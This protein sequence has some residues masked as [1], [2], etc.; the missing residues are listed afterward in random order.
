MPKQRSTIALLLPPLT[1]SAATPLHRQLFDALRAA[2]LDGRLGPEARLPASRAL[3]R[4]LGISRTTVMT[5]YDQLTAEGFLIG[6]SG[7]GT[8]VSETMPGDLI[9]ARA[10]A[11][12]AEAPPTL[13]RRGAVLAGASPHP[14]PPAGRLLRPFRAGY[15]AV[16]AFPTEIWARLAARRWRRGAASLLGYGDP[17]GYLPLRVAIAD[18]LRRSRGVR[19]TEA[20]VIIVSGSQQGFDLT[21][22]LL[23]DPGDVAWVEN[24]GYA[25][26]SGAL[27]GAG[28]RTVPIP[29]DADGLDIA[30]GERLAPEARLAAVTPSHQYPAGVTMTLARR[31]ALLEW[32][33]RASAWVLED[34]Y[35]AEFRYSGRALEA[36]QGLD[37]EG[38]VIYL[39]T[40]S[41]VLAPALRLGYLVV[42][43]A[44]VDAF[45]T[46]VD[47]TSRH[48]P[49]IEQAV[50]ADFI[51]EGHFARH[52]RRMQALY[53]ERQGV[54]VEAAREMAG[55]MLDVRP[56]E[57]GL[58]VVGWLPPG[59]SAVEI[60]RRASDRGV[61]VY[62][63]AMPDEP[64]AG[65]M[66]GYAPFT[67]AA[68]RESMTSL[69]RVLEER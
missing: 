58:H 10:M 65:L 46:A 32:A 45:T 8:F 22:R 18:Y 66:L 56:A 20:Q 47:V 35:D 54:L 5:A 19:C 41:K 1:A 7:S 4:E 36:L 30:A 43:P 17:A 24:P 2:M 34:D 42:P 3:A 28:V 15:P 39:G 67:P 50:L 40:F 29:V 57:A 6:R 38:R 37:S 25:G 31:L 55:D 62:P 49:T 13:S 23:L 11:P 12:P 9:R 53:A 48:A 64:T 51:A 33:A 61:D 14:V 63:F 26:V 16:D 52:L 44:L 27:R 68:I 69:A 21:T 60:A 59:R